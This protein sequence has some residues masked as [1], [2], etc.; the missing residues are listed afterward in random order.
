[1]AAMNIWAAVWKPSLHRLFWM[2]TAGKSSLPGGSYSLEVLASH[3]SQCRFTHSPIL[4]F[5]AV[6]DSCPYLSLSSDSGGVEGSSS[7]SSSSFPAVIPLVLKK[8]FQSSVLLRCHFLY[9]GAISSFTGGQHLLG[10]TA[11]ECSQLQ[12]G[13]VRGQVL[14][15]MDQIPSFIFPNVTRVLLPGGRHC[16]VQEAHLQE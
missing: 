15:S 8:Y 9:F 10:E 7:S 3:H 13:R 14:T 2:E 1:M 6:N 12:K 16:L 5:G 4:W 11:A